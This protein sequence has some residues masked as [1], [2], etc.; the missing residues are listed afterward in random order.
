[1]A[2]ERPEYNDKI[3]LMTAMAPPEYMGNSN[4]PLIQLAVKNMDLLQ[5]N[6]FD[7][8]FISLPFPVFLNSPHMIHSP[9]FPR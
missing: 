6:T 7:K 2:S 1:M 8:H 5:V 4:D 9:V 3:L